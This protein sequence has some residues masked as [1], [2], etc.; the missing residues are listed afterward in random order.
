MQIPSCV[1]VYAASRGTLGC[2][3]QAGDVCWR[4]GAEIHA[5]VRHATNWALDEN[6]NHSNLKDIPKDFH[7]T[8]ARKHFLT[9]LERDIKPAFG[10]AED[11]LASYY[12]EGVFSFGPRYEK[13]VRD[14]SAAAQ[15]TAAVP[16]ATILMQGVMLQLHKPLGPVLCMH[17]V[18]DCG[19]PALP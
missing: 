11:S 19:Q 9:V 18:V 13:L 6:L 16:K 7:P 4:A 5:L 2:T 12:K 15:V 17:M 8:V 1:R 14:I 3:F 10:A